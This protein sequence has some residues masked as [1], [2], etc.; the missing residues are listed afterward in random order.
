MYAVTVIAAALIVVPIAGYHLGVHPNLVVAFFVLMTAADL[1]TAHLLVQQFMA[2]GRL[3][4]L[5]LSSAYLYS[6]LMMVPYAVVFTRSQRLGASSTWA[7]VCAPWLFFLLLAGFPV[8]VAVQQRVVAALPAR[9]SEQARN[10]RRTVAA[11]A[12]AA[13]LALVLA[14]TGV[15]V[16]AADWLPPLQQGGAQTTAG[17]YVLVAALVA[18][19]VSLL[20]VIG[21][22]RR[23]PPVERWVV[24]AISASL[25]TAILRLAAAHRYTLGWYAARVTLLISA[26]VVLLALL[27]ETASLYRRLSAAHEDLDRAHRELSRRA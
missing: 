4:T 14:V 6:S 20:A 27:A 1:L 10:R 17:R 5:G 18:A 7:E 23:R 22:L 9:L 24:V 8:L 25:A 19:A 15:V 21:D 12:A 11:A 26:G 2:G 16:G 13:V 3:A